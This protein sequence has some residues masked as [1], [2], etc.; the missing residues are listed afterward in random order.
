[1]EN[2]VL[3]RLALEQCLQLARDRRSHAQHRSSGRGRLI[4][5]TVVAALLNCKAFLNFGSC[6]AIA[7]RSCKALLPVSFVKVAAL[8]SCKGMM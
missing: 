6:R 5:G 2:S 8:C 4:D 7:P 1:M 3:H